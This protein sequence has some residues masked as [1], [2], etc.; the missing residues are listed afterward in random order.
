[1]IIKIKLQELKQMLEQAN[2]ST[3]GDMH[4]KEFASAVLTIFP[5]CEEFWRVFV[6]PLT[7]RI[8]N[9]GG[10]LGNDIHF[11][12]GIDPQLLKIA[13]AHYSMFLHLGYSHW[14]YIH[15]VP[16]WLENVYTHLATAC[17]LAETVLEKWHLVRLKCQ[18]KPSNILQELHR[19]EFLDLAGEWYDKNY[20]SEYE[21]YYSKGKSKSIDVPKGHNLLR[22]Y[23]GDSKDRKEYATFSNYIRTFRNAIVHD[24]KLGKLIGPDDVIYIPQIDKINKYR[25]W[26]SVHSVAD[27]QQIIENDFIEIGIQAK[28]SIEG[29]EIRLNNLWDKLID[30]IKNEFDSPESNA[31]REMYGIK[32]DDGKDFFVVDKSQDESTQYT[33]YVGL[34]GAFPRSDFTISNHFSSSEESISD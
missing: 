19:D 27:S 7:R 31:F 18:S 4:E 12:D 6:V 33:P 22:E 10:D 16:P 2:F 26:S 11:R 1:M 23:L 30:D 25:T 13:S 34:S 17:D 15:R 29:L 3:Y 9:P 21:H 20:A 14:H 5:N 24:V 32:K 8:E 28:K